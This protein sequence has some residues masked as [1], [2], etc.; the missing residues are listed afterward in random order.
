MGKNQDLNY[1]SKRGDCSLVL[2][3]LCCYQTLLYSNAQTTVLWDCLI[4]VIKKELQIL[5]WKGR[6]KN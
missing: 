3:R 1:T 2:T 6:L 5:K 4:L